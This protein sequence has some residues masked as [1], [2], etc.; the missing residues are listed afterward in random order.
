[1]KPA[2]TREEW[3]RAIEQIAHDEDFIAGVGHRLGD[4]ELRSSRRQELA[5]YFLESGFPRGPEALH[6][7]AAL[8]LHGQ[9]FGFTWEDVATL[10]SMSARDIL[11]AYDS[12]ADR[13][14]ALLPPETPFQREL[15]YD[16]AKR[17]YEQRAAAILGELEEEG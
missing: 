13:I 6:A 12:I 2:L 16:A 15:R 8:C 5:A 4:A 17:R 7:A 14:E 1:M 11:D 3:E 9:P 10:R